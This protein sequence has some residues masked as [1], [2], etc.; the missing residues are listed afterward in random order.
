MDYTL[1]LSSLF[2]YFTVIFSTTQNAEPSRMYCSLFDARFCSGSDTMIDEE[3]I[4]R[5]QQDTLGTTSL[6]RR[7]CATLCLLST[8]KLAYDVN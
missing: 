6:C 3:V 1:K 7:S 8:V 4:P 5:R 2:F